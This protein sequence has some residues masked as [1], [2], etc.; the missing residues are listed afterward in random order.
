MS[1]QISPVGSMPNV[2][3]AGPSFKAPRLAYAGPASTEIE[4]SSLTVRPGRRSVSPDTRT[5]PARISACARSR[6]SARPLL[7]TSTSS[8]GID[9]EDQP[10]DDAKDST[11]KDLDGRVPQ[12]LAQLLFLDASHVDEVF[13]QAIQDGGLAA[14]R[15]P[16]TGGVIH[17]HER[18]DK[19][20]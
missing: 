1:A 5:L 18:E 16:K 11:H 17:H 10:H 9:L 20:D 15:A 2:M 13:D 3:S 19:R 4:A 14:R 8:L 7:A 6:D 12:E